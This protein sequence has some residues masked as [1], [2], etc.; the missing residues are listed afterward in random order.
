MYV[1]IQIHTY[2]FKFQSESICLMLT[3]DKVH[4]GEFIR[5]N[6]CEQNGI[7]VY[8][9]LLLTVSEICVVINIFQVLYLLLP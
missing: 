1:K 9:Y 6:S 8:V 4:C 3:Y 2:I 7:D 5:D